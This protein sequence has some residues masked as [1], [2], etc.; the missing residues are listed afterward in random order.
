MLE[1]SP[2]QDATHSHFDEEPTRASLPQHMTRCSLEA[3]MLGSAL[4]PRDMRHTVRQIGGMCDRLEACATDWRH[5]LHICQ[6]DTCLEQRQHMTRRRLE[7]RCIVSSSC[8]LS[9]H[10]C[11]PRQLCPSMLA[12]SSLPRHVSGVCSS[13]LGCWVLEYSAVG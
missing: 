9:G 3:E 12:S 13:T 10:A 5:V 2:R 6:G 7:H 1:C 4:E 11:L 8:V